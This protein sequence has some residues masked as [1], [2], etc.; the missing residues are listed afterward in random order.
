MHSY[1]PRVRTKGPVWGGRGFQRGRGRNTADPR[2]LPREAGTEVV[3]GARGGGAGAFTADPR[4]Y[5]G[6]RMKGR[7]EPEGGREPITADPRFLPRKRTEGG[8]GSP[9]GGGSLM[10]S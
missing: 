2:V 9:R 5:R 3:G 10:Y 1:V 8:G 4:F 6:K 7:G